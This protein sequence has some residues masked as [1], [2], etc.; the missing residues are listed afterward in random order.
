MEIY[1]NLSG[2]SGVYAF[3]I[4]DDFLVL[5]FKKGGTYRYS[6]GSAGRRNIEQMKV[7]ARRGQGLGTFISK[8]LKKT[9]KEKS[10]RKQF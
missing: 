3:Q 7:L 10:D 4:G 8:N 9:M 6:Y 1:K 2:D 5:Q